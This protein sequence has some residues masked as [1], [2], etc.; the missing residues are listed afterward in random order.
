MVAE[1]LGPFVEQR[2]S[3]QE[4]RAEERQRLKRAKGHRP[5]QEPHESV[6][7]LRGK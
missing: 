7:E 5:G 3:R 2:L 1:E 6:S 4:R